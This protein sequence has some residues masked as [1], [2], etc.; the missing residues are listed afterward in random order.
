MG[1]SKDG[2]AGRGRQ[3]S[4]HVDMVRGEAAWSSEKESWV[5]KKEQS[6]EERRVADP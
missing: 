1:E 4:G 2:K 3:M 6:G 5:N